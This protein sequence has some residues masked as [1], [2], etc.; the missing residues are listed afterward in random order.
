MNILVTGGAGFVGSNLV[1]KLIKL[2]HKVTIFDNLSTGKKNNLNQSAEF[3][4]VDI[5]DSKKIEKF[6]RGREWD[7]VFHLAALA[8]I[9][10]SFD[11]PLEVQQ[12][13]VIGTVNML[14]IARKNQ[15]K[16]VYPGSSTAYHDVFA[17]PYAFSKYTGEQYCKLYN[18]VFGISTV[19]ARFFNVYGPRHISEGKYATVIAIWERQ[20]A[21]NEEL[22][23]T[24]DGS[25]RRDFTHVNDITEGLIELS[26]GNWNAEVFNLGTGKNYSILEVARMFNSKGIKFL[27]DRRGEAQ[28]TLADISKTIKL[29]NWK[30]TMDIKDYIKSLC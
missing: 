1:D 6:S 14:E 8:R 22:T 28:E 27:P 15:A 23:V 26:K 9:Q 18:Q 12:V 30:P 4:K 25:K 7:I 29:I 13:N 20:M 5:A 3:I 17:N 21:E 10:P 19:I 24:G 11:N 2:K 16:F